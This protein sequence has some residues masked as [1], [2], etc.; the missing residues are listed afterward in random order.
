[1]IVN[2][3]P[4]ETLVNSEDFSDEEDNRLTTRIEYSND[5]VKNSDIAS[6][7]QIGQYL[8]IGKPK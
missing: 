2:E 1:M 4:D 8:S 7:R 5:L 6:I 3:K